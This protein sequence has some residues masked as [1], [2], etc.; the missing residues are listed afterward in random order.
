MVVQQIKNPKSET[1]PFL[2]A[3]FAPVS[4]ENICAELKTTG[5]IPQELS[6]RFL[7]IGPN[8]V[9]HPNSK[10]YHWFMGAGMVHGLRIENGRALWYKNNYVMTNNVAADL[11]RSELP[12]PRKTRGG[13]VNTNVMAIAGD[14]YALVEAGSLPVKLNNN[15]ESIEHSDFGG[16]LNHGLSAHPRRDPQ[17]GELHVLAYQ[18]TKPTVDYLVIDQSGK[19]ITKSQIHLPHQ[20]MIHDTAITSNYV[21]VLDFPVTFSL[22]TAVTGTFPYVWN[23]KRPSR[24]GLLPRDG[25]SSKTLWTEIPTS[26]AYHIMNAYEDHDDVIV[27]VVKNAMNF[28]AKIEG[29]NNKAPTL[30]RWTINLKSGKFF[31][32][33]LSERSV[34]FPRINDAYVGKQYRYGYTATFTSDL[35]FGAAYKHDL[36]EGQTLVHDYGQGRRTLEPVFVSKSGAV[37]E[38]EGW[39]LSYVFDENTHTTDV[40][41]LDAQNFEGEPV[42]TIHLPV[43]VPFGFHGNW[44]ADAELR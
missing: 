5:N 36:L 12:T 25:D 28:D 26:F 2:R 21:V 37:S 33:I 9:T 6:G 39:L 15:L 29:R 4:T 16:T 7:R 22:L 10:S 44:I 41:I 23:H 42:A 11:K 13:S 38:D 27:D 20:P 24:I 32:T 8:P 43:R 31:E 14:L 35:Q 34:E 40:V 17:T 1:N 18:P 30:V 19:A 3:N